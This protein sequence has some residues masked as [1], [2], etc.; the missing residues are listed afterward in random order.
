VLVIIIAVC[1]LTSATTVHAETVYNVNW[2]GLAVKGYDPVAYFTEKMP[3][4]SNEQFELEWEGAWWR[5][6]SSENLEMFRKTPERHVP[7]YGDYCAYGVAVG[8]LYDIKP[9]AW[10]IVDGRLYLNKNL[11]VRKIWKQD[12]PGYIEKAN[13]N[14]PGLRISN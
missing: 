8:A 14:W 11:R 9:E 3:I 12:I 4:K 2:K 7:L 1:W 6:A 5:F 10:S 13:A